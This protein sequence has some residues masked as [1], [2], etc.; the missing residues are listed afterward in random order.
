MK[1]WAC[2]RVSVGNRS[3]PFCD[4][5]NDPKRVLKQGRLCCDGTA[6]GVAVEGATERLGSL[7]KCTFSDLSEREGAGSPS[8]LC[9]DGG[10][11]PNLGTE[12]AIPAI[13]AVER[14]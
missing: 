7:S 9:V 1:T 14:R 8:Q 11:E 10:R 4:V 5:D 6:I 2:E 3:K 13:F 12:R